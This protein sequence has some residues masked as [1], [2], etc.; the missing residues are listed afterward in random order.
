MQKRDRAAGGGELALFMAVIDQAITDATMQLP[1]MYVWSKRKGGKIL[2]STYA[3]MK[4]DRD[5]AYK[6]LT[7]KE[8]GQNSNWAG[9]FRRI[10]H[11][12]G[13]NPDY[14]RRKIEGALLRR[15][16]RR[17]SQNYGWRRE[18]A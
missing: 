1:P 2:N 9:S 14:V 6:F 5:E 17:D 16:S 18:A 13:L 7:A 8:D 15:K 4:R 11:A 10:C 12:A 3:N